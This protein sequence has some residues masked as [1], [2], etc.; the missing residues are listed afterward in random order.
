MEELLFLYAHDIAEIRWRSQSIV[1]VLV[2]TKQRVRR[3]S[4]SML[5]L[6]EQCYHWELSNGME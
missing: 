4:L 5:S 1:Q 2:L 3:N 6:H